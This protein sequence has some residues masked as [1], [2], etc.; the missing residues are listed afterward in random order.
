MLKGGFVVGMEVA[1]V[2]TPSD[3]SNR[4]FKAIGHHPLNRRLLAHASHRR[5]PMQSSSAR[6][7]NPLKYISTIDDR[8]YTISTSTGRLSI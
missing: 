8:Y 6:L 2:L 1:Y 7:L 3:F 4:L 5:A